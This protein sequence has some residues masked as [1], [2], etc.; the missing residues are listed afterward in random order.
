[1]G[2]SMSGPLDTGLTQQ[3]R[4]PTWSPDRTQIAFA[5]GPSSGPF[6]VYVFD[7]TKPGSLP[8]SIGTGDRPA[9]SPDGTRIA[10]ESGNDIIVHPVAGGADLNLTTTLTPKAWKAAWSPDS[11]TLYYSV[12]DISQP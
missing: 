4:H 7:L 12:G 11:Q 1:G 5:E 2:G 9:W 8:Q 3:H 10:Y 6:S